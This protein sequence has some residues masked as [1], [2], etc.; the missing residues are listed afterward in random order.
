MVTKLTI[1]SFLGLILL[2]P[3]LL[4]YGEKSLFIGS[5]QF[6]SILEMVPNVRV[7]YCGRK[8]STDID[9]FGK[10]IMYSVPEHKQRTFFYI[11][12]TPDI[13]FGS[14]ENT[15]PFLKLKKSCP[16]KF[17]ALQL[18]PYET[19]KKQNKKLGNGVERTQ[20]AYT[21]YVKELDLSV[22]GGRIP[23]ETIIVCYNPDF[24]QSVEG[25]NA[26]EFPKLVIKPDI[27]KLVG[28]EEKL[29]QISNKWF[30]A[31]LDTD[32]IHESLQSE[33]KITPQ[34]KTVIAMTA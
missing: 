13:E 8:I 7:Y 1:F 5:I 23:D 30:L 32:T 4:A 9:E 6:P 31:A 20:I 25:G 24:I 17:Y 14:H 26:I 28:S 34:S 16:Y 29:H 21:W 18:V 10:K 27:L 19:P 22:S 12:V 15:V 2:A 11:L 33:F 3:Q